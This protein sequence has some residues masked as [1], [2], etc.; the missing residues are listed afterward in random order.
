MNEAVAAQLS[1]RATLL[2]SPER[3]THR[4][5]KFRHEVT[6]VLLVQVMYPVDIKLGFDE[7]VRFNIY[8][9][10]YGAMQLEVIGSG[11]YLAII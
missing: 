1:R 11:Y 2:V 7:Q 8:L 6:A 9:H 10:A 3:V 5:G 4:E